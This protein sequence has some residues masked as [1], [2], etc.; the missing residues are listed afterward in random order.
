MKTLLLLLSFAAIVTLNAQD[1]FKITKDEKS[2]KQMIIGTAGRQALQDTSFAWWYNSEYDNYTVKMKDLEGVAPKLDSVNITIVM[3]TWCS[4]SR[5]EIPRFLKML[6][7][8]GFQQQKLHL[9]FV[10][11]DRKDLSGEVD[12]LKIELVPTIL[13]YRNGKE[14]GRI[15]EAPAETLEI[16]TKKIVMNKQQI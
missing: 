6:D 9:I 10:D 15:T 3:A 4:D 12:S 14:I 11:K 13:F 1:S 7:T 2:G 16:D 8:L 5:R